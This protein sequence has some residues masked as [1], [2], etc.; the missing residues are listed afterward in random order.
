MEDRQY[1]EVALC[2]GANWNP[3]SVIRLLSLERGFCT[4]FFVADQAHSIDQG[5]LRMGMIEVIAQKYR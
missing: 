2:N 1:L 3:S 5:S 4:G